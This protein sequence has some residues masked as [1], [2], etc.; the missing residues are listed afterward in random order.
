MIGVVALRRRVL[1]QGCRPPTDL[2]RPSFLVFLVWWP[3]FVVVVA[4]E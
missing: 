4:V 3:A 1:L 2:S